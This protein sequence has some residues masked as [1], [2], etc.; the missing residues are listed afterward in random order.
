MEYR[1][2]KT[3]RLGPGEPL[4]DVTELALLHD[5]EVDAYSLQLLSAP[6]EPSAAEYWFG[7]LE[8]A[9]R[10]AGLVFGTRFTGW[11]DVTEPG[12]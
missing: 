1:L 5:P 9:E 8:Q 12:T 6:G 4:P 7:S 10:Q 2:L 11:T 3:A